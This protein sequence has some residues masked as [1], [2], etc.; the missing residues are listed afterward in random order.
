MVLLDDLLQLLKQT[1]LN[2]YES[3]A[4]AVLLELGSATAA[5]VSKKAGVPRARVYDVL[6][7]LEKKGFLSQELGRPVRFKAFHPEAAISNLEQAKKQSFAVELGQ[8]SELKAVLGKHA[9][10]MEKSSEGSGE[11]AFLLSGSAS[12]EA[13]LKEL[14]K[15]AQEE[16]IICTNEANAMKK[17]RL[18]GRILSENKVNARVS[19]CSPLGESAELKKEFQDA[20]VG[21]LQSGNSARFMVFDNKRALLFLNHEKKDAEKALLIDSP[22]IARFLKETIL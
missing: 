11:S 21:F 16:A 14:L 1:G 4:Y 10:S 17:A 3:K 15:S 20:N 9:D 2:E 7:S 22:S 5:D 6:L 19:F 18:L 13:K 12:I 8:L